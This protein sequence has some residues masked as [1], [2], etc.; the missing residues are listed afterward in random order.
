M[1]EQGCYGLLAEFGSPE[2]L[3]AGARKAREEGYRVLDA[4]TPFPVDGLAQVL[5]LHERR[6]LRL[7]LFGG[8]FGF[9]VAIAM[10]CA[11]NW[12]YP[13]NVGGRPL[14]AL[15]AFAVVTFEL[16]VLF[17]ALLPAFGMLVLNGLPR[18]HHPVFAAPRFHLASRD[19][20]FLCVL[21]NDPMFDESVTAEFL[22][23]L[24]P[25]SIELVAV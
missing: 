10:Q 14:Y 22:R 24:Q 7:G 21:A 15:S 6:I 18:L 19:R 25:A 13:I 4:F 12:S 11:T 1:A 16:I 3:L 2:A 17:A 5:D 23:S 9:A 20:F 8:C